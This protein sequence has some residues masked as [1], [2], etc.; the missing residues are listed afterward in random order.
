[1]LIIEIIV[2]IVVLAFI[3]NGVRAG[4]VETLGRVLGAVIGFV[5]ARSFASWLVGVVGMFLPAEWAYLVSFVGIFLLVDYG[6][7]LLFKLAENLLKI[8]T[9][10]PILKQLNS[11]IGGVLGFLEAVIVIGGVSWL[12]EQSASSG[13]STLTIMDLRTVEFIRSIFE[14]IFKTFL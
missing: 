5:V 9:R 12:L 1:M 2:L 7:G 14:I 3:A 11:V 8:F 4:A 10:L 6:V 13:E